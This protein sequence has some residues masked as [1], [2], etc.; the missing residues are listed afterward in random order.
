M[1]HARF[2]KAERELQAARP[3]GY[4]PRKFYESTQLVKG[5]VDPK[6]VD[7]TKEMPAEPPAEKVDSKENEKK[8][9]RLYVAMTS[10]RGE[11]IRLT[12][13]HYYL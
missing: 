13:Y 11:L 5:A 8:I 3:F 9:K 7:K 12:L 2:I 1:H 6:K 10:D 4:G